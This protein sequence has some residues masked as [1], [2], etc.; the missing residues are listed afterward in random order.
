MRRGLAETE[1]AV[2]RD[3]P[4]KAGRCGGSEQIEAA[5]AK[6]ALVDRTDL[7]GRELSVGRGRAMPDEAQCMW[8]A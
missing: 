6:L 3:H 4:G 2:G 5:P 1:R 7:H 8:P